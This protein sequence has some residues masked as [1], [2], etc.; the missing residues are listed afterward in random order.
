MFVLLLMGS[1]FFIFC[2]GFY[3]EYCLDRVLKNAPPA[4]DQAGRKR[5]LDGEIDNIT[6]YEV[7]RNNVIVYG[8]QIWVLLLG[9]GGIFT[10]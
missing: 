4:F 10:L 5:Y 9:I 1:L 2:V 8:F 7:Y 6:K 3:F